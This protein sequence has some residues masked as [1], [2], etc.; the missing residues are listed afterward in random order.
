[1]SKAWIL[2]C[3]MILDGI[4]TLIA[5]QNADQSHLAVIGVYA[6]VLIFIVLALIGKLVYGWEDMSGHGE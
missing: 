1:M 2:T 3:L 4:G 6:G 5:Y